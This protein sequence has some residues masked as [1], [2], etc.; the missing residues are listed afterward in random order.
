LQI[1][2]MTMDTYDLKG[3]WVNRTAFLNQ[4]DRKAGATLKDG[5]IFRLIGITV[6][7]VTLACFLSKSCDCCTGDLHEELYLAPDR[8]ADLCDRLDRDAR[9]LESKQ[10]MDYSLLLGIKKDVTEFERSN[11]GGEERC[12]HI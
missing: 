10:I 2:K 12:A 8:H 1:Q 3:S 9:F 11:G 7:S 6:L 5:P 4:K